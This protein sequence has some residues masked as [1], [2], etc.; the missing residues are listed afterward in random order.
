MCAI[1]SGYKPGS[2]P[3]IDNLASGCSDKTRFSA[4]ICA[5][6]SFLR[7]NHLNIDAIIKR[8]SE[9]SLRSTAVQS[10]LQISVQFCPYILVRTE[11]R[12]LIHFATHLRNPPFL[13]NLRSPVIPLALRLWCQRKTERHHREKLQYAHGHI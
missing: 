5:S 6:K 12:Y 3:V 10:V 4:S 13:V 1:C 2:P 11:E 9:R 7:R 8:A